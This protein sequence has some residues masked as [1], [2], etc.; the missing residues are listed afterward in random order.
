MGPRSDCRLAPLLTVILAASCH[1]AAPERPVSVP[2]SAAPTAADDDG[3]RQAAEDCAVARQ[4]GS[5]ADAL[6]DAGRSLRAALFAEQA[7]RRCASLPP[8]PAAP[9]P[10]DP[11]AQL[12]AVRTWIARRDPAL[13]LAPQRLPE[14]VIAAA[15]DAATLALGAAEPG[16]LTLTPRRI[17]Y[18]IRQ[19]GSWVV[20][21]E[22]LLRPGEWLE[23]LTFAV[24]PGSGAGATVVAV[25]SDRWVLVR[26]QGAA[27]R[28]IAVDLADGTTVHE[29]AAPSSAEA[30]PLALD[31]GSVLVPCTLPA[32]RAADGAPAAETVELWQL[33]P[34][35]RRA[36]FDVPTVEALSEPVLVRS[37]R[38]PSPGPREARG[39]AGSFGSYV[40]ESFDAAA[41][42]SSSSSPEPAVE[43]I[44]A[45]GHDLV[46]ITWRGALSLID[47]RRGEPI[48]AFAREPG[49]TL[50]SA[51]ASASEDGRFVGFAPAVDSIVVLDRA[52]GQARA[53]TA[54]GAANHR[55]PRF[56]PD[57]LKVV[58]G[59]DFDFGYLWDTVSGRLLR[60]LPTPFPRRPIVE[61]EGMLEPL[62]F[63]RGGREVLLATSITGSVRRFDVAT[64]R[65]LTA[66]SSPA[67]GITRVVR[68]DRSQ[69]FFDGLAQRVGEVTAD[70]A[71]TP[72]A[73]AFAGIVLG[74]TPDGEWLVRASEPATA[75]PTG[76][77]LRVEVVSTRSDVASR[78][79]TQP[80]D[81]LW[82]SP[83]ARFV[84][85]SRGSVRRVEDG[86][87]IL[88]DSTGGAPSALDRMDDESL[89]FASGLVLD[90]RTGQLC[91]APAASAPNP[92]EPGSGANL[93][94]QDG[95]D[96]RDALRTNCGTDGARLRVTRGGHPI[97]ERPGCARL[98]AAADEGA[99]L[100]LAVGE[101]IVL[102]RSA[103]GEERLVAVPQPVE[104][105]ILTP[106]PRPRAALALRNR[107]RRGSVPASHRLAVV[108][109]TDGRVLWSIA[110]ADRYHDL[111]W[112]THV[113]TPVVRARV[114]GERRA[115]AV[116]DGQ[117]L[118]RWPTSAPWHE[119]WGG[120][121][122]A[123]VESR[124][125]EL[126]SLVPPEHRLAVAAPERG[127]LL[128]TADDGR[129]ELLG[130]REPLARALRC[131]LGP[132]VL[133][134]S[135]CL[136]RAEW[137][138]LTA[139]LLATLRAGAPSP[140]PNARPPGTCTPARF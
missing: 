35:L 89:R 105:A 39:I 27:P 54:P 76:P 21:D 95:R 6:R 59:G 71:F 41:T 48:A 36:R 138:G 123:F 136:E 84:F 31:D 5:Q 77:S 3:A 30:T 93:A 115:H 119:L 103:S 106:G 91:A 81:H 34:P 4:L 18:E 53:M 124:R 67:P 7:R 131:R 82:L 139:E 72:R 33:S 80:A 137:P 50:L 38:L 83:D 8:A 127:S 98:L 32:A 102:H 114:G 25:V 126:V 85:G 10:R 13:A 29:W 113:G 2:R 44:D 22:T 64:G 74:A 92:A 46:A 15:L 86:S 134:L 140:A 24:E 100:L 62:G 16:R 57:G 120:R 118:E 26:E 96:G 73:D 116:A 37:P 51:S 20:R 79:W 128:V 125:V 129:V 63:A 133:P 40:P 23:R 117:E 111:A 75:A 52:T 45:L 97:A 112:G 132:E 122:L 28:V 43:R 69:V 70:G 56:S 107:G 94:A 90:L 130:D 49:Q 68:A 61:D 66:P 1:T 58:T 104:E 55:A 108:D 88:P 101:G 121:A 135:A 11:R 60:T 110:G 65:E 87:V 42:T 9:H 19:L 78:T 14:P 109:L 99:L 47:G 12:E 17:A